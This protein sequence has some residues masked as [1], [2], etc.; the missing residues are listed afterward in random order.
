[1]NKGT[2]PGGLIWFNEWGS[3]RYAANTAFVAFVY[4]DSK[5]DFAKASE[6]REWALGQLDYLLGKNA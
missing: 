1:M 2:T 3:A 6:T 5:K 4:A